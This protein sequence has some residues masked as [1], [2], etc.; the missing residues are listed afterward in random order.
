M[1]ASKF[2]SKVYTIRW[3]K[4]RYKKIRVCY[5]DS[6]PLARKVMELST[7]SLFKRSKSGYFSENR[8][9]NLYI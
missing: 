6:I 5:K 8:E 4:Y 9:E 3:K 2:E 7:F 1:K